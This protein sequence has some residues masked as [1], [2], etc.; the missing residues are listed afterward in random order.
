MSCNLGL[1]YGLRATRSKPPGD[2]FGSV[3]MPGDNRHLSNPANLRLIPVERLLSD[4]PFTIP[5]EQREDF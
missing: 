5:L 4:Q 1:I 2:A 3:K